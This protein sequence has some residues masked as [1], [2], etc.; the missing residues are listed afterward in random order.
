MKISFAFILL[1]FKRERLS[2]GPS[3]IPEYEQ[4][5][6]VERTMIAKLRVLWL[7]REAELAPKPEE[8]GGATAQPASLS[9][10]ITHL[11]PSFKRR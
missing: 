7:A 11:E 5:A 2:G 8:T 3:S 1:L 10:A 6:R 4:R 9:S